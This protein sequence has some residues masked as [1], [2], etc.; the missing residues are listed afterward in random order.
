MQSLFETE[1]SRVSELVQRKLIKVE[2]VNEIFNAAGSNAY[3]RR[4]LG[5]KEIF[6]TFFVRVYNC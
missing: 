3:G 1:S 4:K 6:G 2:G 5:V